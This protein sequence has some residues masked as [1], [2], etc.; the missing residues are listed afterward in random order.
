MKTAGKYAIK[1][2]VCSG[3]DNSGFRI[4]LMNNGNEDQLA[5]VSV[6]NKGW[7][8]YYVTNEI[9]LSKDLS[10]GQQ[11]IR[12]TITGVFCNIDKIEFIC[13]EEDAV[14]YIF[15]DDETV[16]ARYNIGGILVGDDYKG[17]SIINGKKVLR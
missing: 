15:K 17:I 4:G 10:E 6:S 14:Y 3:L 2:T 7:G 5:N 13:T 11:T 8:N 9:A 1:A 16:G 12:I